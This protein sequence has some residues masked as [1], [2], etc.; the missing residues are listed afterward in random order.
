MSKFGSILKKVE[1]AKGQVG[2]NKD[3][4]GHT[5]RDK[6]KKGQAWT[7]RDK[8]GQKWKVPVCPCLTL[9]V[10]ALSLLVLACPCLDKINFS[11]NLTII[12]NLPSGNSNWLQL[13][14][15]P[16]LCYVLINRPCVAGTV[17]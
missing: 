16:F 7:D 9:F 6:D 13:Y 17:L 3:K 14:P 8:Q 5:E 15:T 2:T 1:Q 4:Q 12:K 11:S 10:P